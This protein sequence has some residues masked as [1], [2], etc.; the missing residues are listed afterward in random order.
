V[1]CRDAIISNVGRK[2][3]RKTAEH[4]SQFQ[5]LG[6]LAGSNDLHARSVFLRTQIWHTDIYQN[7][8]EKFNLGLC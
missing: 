7:F 2:R 3:E 4:R 5:C 8:T 6:N 1:S